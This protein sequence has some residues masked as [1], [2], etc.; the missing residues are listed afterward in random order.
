MSTTAWIVALDR[1]EFHAKLAFGIHE[2]L[3]RAQLGRIEVRPS[4]CQALE[5]KIS[6]TCASP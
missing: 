3:N 5:L 6:T 4:V 2:W 1:R